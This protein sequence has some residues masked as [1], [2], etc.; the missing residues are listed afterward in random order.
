MKQHSMKR[1]NRWM[2]VI[3][4]SFVICQ[5]SISAALAQRTVG[6]T[7]TDA[8]TG[9]PL[10]GVIVEAYGNHKYTAMT[11]E[12]GQYQLEVPDFVTTPPPKRT[13]R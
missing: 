1:P 2:K 3:G 4:L 6:G 5:L 12:K 10:A 11:D 13:G 7:V 9:K 8:A